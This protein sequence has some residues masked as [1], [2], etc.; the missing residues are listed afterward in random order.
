M[1]RVGLPPVNGEDECPQRVP[2]FKRASFPTLTTHPAEALRTFAWGNG[3]DRS[4]D[5]DSGAPYALR[6]QRI[7]FP[8]SCS[9][10]WPWD[11]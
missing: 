6:G 4:V 10:R 2:D 8:T 3:Q 9:H 5:Y 1:L 7:P 11:S